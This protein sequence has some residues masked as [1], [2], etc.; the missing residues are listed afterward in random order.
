MLVQS[1]SKE[2]GNSLVKDVSRAASSVN[3]TRAE[4][5]EQWN[6]YCHQPVIDIQ[7]PAQLTGQNMQSTLS[8]K[9]AMT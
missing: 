8:V 5:G 6:Y 9:M 7:S 2:K 4:C 3:A 1:G